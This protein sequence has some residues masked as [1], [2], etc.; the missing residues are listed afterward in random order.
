MSAVERSKKFQKKEDERKEVRTPM[1]LS[2]TSALQ[3]YSETKNS[4]Q[5][6]GKK[7]KLLISMPEKESLKE[8]NGDLNTRLKE[9]IGKVHDKYANLVKALEFKGENLNFEAI[10]EYLKKTSILL[11]RPTYTRD[12]QRAYSKSPSS[13]RRTR[14]GFSE[15][16][17]SNSEKLGLLK[18]I[19]I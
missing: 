13:Y 9:F 5:I 1:V 6:S 17:Y 11:M 16:G 4:F 14:V 19:D 12:K 15:L 10:V 8:E 7:A 2:K 3:S 18:A